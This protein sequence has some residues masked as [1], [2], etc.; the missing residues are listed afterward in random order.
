MKTLSVK[1]LLLMLFSMLAVISVHANGESTVVLKDGSM[2][3]GYI[4]VQRPGTD[5]L[6]DALSTEIADNGSN[7]TIKSQKNVRFEQ[8]SREWKRW[9]LLHKALTGNAD[10]RF[11]RL[12]TIEADGRTFTDVA[13][14]EGDA[15]NS[16]KYI[17]VTP[18]NVSL[19]WNNIDEVRKQTS[20]DKGLDDEIITK[21]GKKYKGT[22]VKQS[23][24][25]WI[26]IKDGSLTSRIKS[27]DI[28]ETRKVG[29]ST[30]TDIF[31]S[32]GYT[33]GLLLKNG[34]LKEGVIVEQHYGNSSKGQY[35]SLLLENG[36]K[37]NVDANE[38]EEFRT[39]YPDRKNSYAR[40]R[41]YVNEFRINQ[42]MTKKEGGKTAYVDKTVY[43]FPEGIVNTFKTAGT[44]LNGSWM[45]VALEMV[46]LNSG[47][48]SEGF[49]N[50][51]R[52]SN[53]IPPSSTDYSD[54][55]SS[56]SFNYLAPGYYALVND[57]NEE[58][59]IIKITR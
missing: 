47:T 48:E 34:Q 18:E 49:T 16:K 1:Q 46:T 9:A 5:M 56:I 25:G 45:L 41:M 32:A 52:E 42:A 40:G 39:T 4:I 30:S 6:V 43:T 33:N 44:K 57:D 51:T 11:L 12:Y 28:I 29:A 13:K 27:S 15:K 24:K 54:G 17:D 3:T 7:V 37:E 2:I 22:I 21:G 31:A 8:L 36:K 59:Y 53:A 58:T 38:I 10:G 50:E 23:F 35:V 14:L 20:N 19:K 55:V 26:D